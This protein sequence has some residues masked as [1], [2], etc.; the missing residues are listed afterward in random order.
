MNALNTLFNIGTVPVA[1]I[2]LTKETQK[3]DQNKNTH[4]KEAFAELVP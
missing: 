3:I 1:R 2:M 4:I